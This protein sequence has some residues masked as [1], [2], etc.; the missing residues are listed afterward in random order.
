MMIARFLVTSTHESISKLLVYFTEWTRNHVHLR[1]QTS[2]PFFFNV[3]SSNLNFILHLS[4]ALSLIVMRRM[5]MKTKEKEKERF[6][7]FSFPFLLAVLCPHGSSTNQDNDFI[8]FLFEFG[9]PNS[10]PEISSHFSKTIPATTK[11]KSW[12]VKQVEGKTATFS[13]RREVKTKFPSL[14]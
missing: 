6:S 5:N 13:F 4:F 3:M 12:E 14:D 2:S 1:T 11:T 9:M 8:S 10:N 7:F